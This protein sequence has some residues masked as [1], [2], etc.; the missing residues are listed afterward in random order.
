MM[1]S[2]VSIYIWLICLPLFF[3]V[4]LVAAEEPIIVRLSTECRLVP[5]YVQK[6][7]G[8]SADFEA[9]YLVELERVLAFDLNYNGMTKL[10]DRTPERERRISVAGFEGVD[11]LT[12]WKSDRVHYLVKA[13]IH[14][15]ALTLRAVSINSRFAQNIEAVSLT[16]ELAKDRRSIHQLAD[17]LHRVFFGRD[18]VA[19]TKLLYTVK[20]RPG[21]TQDSTQW[22]SEVWECDYDGANPR[23]ITHENRLCLNPVYLPPKTA[24]SSP[25]AFFYVS[26]KTGIPKIYLASLSEGTS[27]RFSYVSGNQL[28]PAISMQRHRLAFICDA[29]GN[30][31][32]FLHDI[33]PDATVVG[34]PRQI[35]S[36]GRA[37]QGSPSFNPNGRQVAFVSN[38]DGT[39][40]IYIM[41][42]P[43]AG[44]AAAKPATTLITKRNRENTA[45]AWSPDGTKIA[46]CALTGNQRQI[47]VADL[48]TG[49]ER[50]LTQGPGN[51]ENP[52]W[53]PDSLHLIFNSA[54]DNSSELYLV[55]L[56]QPEAIK[57]SSGLGEKRFPCWEPRWAGGQ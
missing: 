43:P 24:N 36:F 52:S 22:V 10:A 38:K 54:S 44:K 53:A 14:N 30:S 45:P 42:I 55:N 9:S 1:R 5:I 13:K 17:A 33:G 31:D 48:T 57:I 35:Y 21:G 12:G 32:L 39:P 34:K 51:K 8:I 6:F 20:R 25:T 3:Q 15:K 56:N 4:K 46:Y 26:Y 23:Q 2:V 28:M 37:A 27:R 11:D 16:G 29:T 50:Q 19:G 18:G 49:Q 47:W 40:H 41:D 7:E